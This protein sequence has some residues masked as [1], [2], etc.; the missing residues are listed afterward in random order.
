MLFVVHRQVQFLSVFPERVLRVVV[1]LVQEIGIVPVLPFNWPVYQFVQLLLLRVNCVFKLLN[2]ER[3]ICGL[4]KARKLL[5]YFVEHGKFFGPFFNILP[6]VSRTLL[7]VLRRG[8]RLPLRLRGGDRLV[9][10]ATRL[11]T[12]MRLA[13]LRFRLLW[14]CARPRGYRDR[15][16]NEGPVLQ[17]LRR[18]RLRGRIADFSLQL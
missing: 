9:S 10:R 14:L 2:H 3:V 11:V 7:Y 6:G 12:W 4:L 8:Y 13:C 18:Y 5:V 15:L 16:A 17:R 1:Y